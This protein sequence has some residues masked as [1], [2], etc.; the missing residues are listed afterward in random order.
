MLRRPIFPRRL[1]PPAQP[2]RFSVSDG[3]SG[4]LHWPHRGGLRW[5]DLAS[6]WLVVM[7]RI[8]SA[9]ARSEASWAERSARAALCPVGL[10][11]RFQPAQEGAFSTGLDSRQK[12]KREPSHAAAGTE[13]ASDLGNP[14]PRRCA[15][16]S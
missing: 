15:R 8:E 13:S 7:R 2:G 11:P 10:L 9:R 1:K 16:R 14:A 12:L 5:P 6:V 3:R 4:R